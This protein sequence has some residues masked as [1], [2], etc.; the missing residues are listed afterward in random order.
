MPSG[1]SLFSNC[2]VDLT[3]NKLDC[4]KGEHCMERFCKDFRDHVLKII[5]Y[6]EKE[7]MLLTDSENKSYEK[8]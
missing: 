4:Y 6:E 2:S 3:K 1:Y 8:Q 7:M 5:N